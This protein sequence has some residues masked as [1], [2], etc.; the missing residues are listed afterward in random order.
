MDTWNSFGPSASSERNAYALAELGFDPEAPG[1]LDVGNLD[2]ASD[3]LSSGFS[4]LR[5]VYDEAFAAAL[6]EVKRRGL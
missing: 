2:S 6:E 3:L 1:V 5:R 4:P